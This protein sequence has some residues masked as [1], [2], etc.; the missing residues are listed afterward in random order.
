[1]GAT[2][3]RMFVTVLAR[4]PDGRLVGQS[5]RGGPE[6]QPFC[7]QPGES[8][9]RTPWH[10]LAELVGR[11]PVRLIDLPRDDP[12]LPGET[13]QQPR[14]RAEAEER[15]RAAR[16]AKYGTQQRDGP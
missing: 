7:V 10:V 13:E 8:F 6:V 4:L 11:G 3:G 15:R 9:L 16:R 12:A 1:M 2:P 14:P 5:G